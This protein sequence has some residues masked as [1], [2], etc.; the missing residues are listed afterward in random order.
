[1]R[2]TAALTPPDL[3]ALTDTLTDC[4]HD[5]T[6]SLPRLAGSARAAIGS[7]LGLSVPIAAAAQEIA[8]TAMKEP[9][10]ADVILKSLNVPLTPE[11]HRPGPQSRRFT[12]ASLTS[13]LS[14]DTCFRRSGRR[15]TGG[16]SPWPSRSPHGR[17]GNRR[18][19]PITMTTK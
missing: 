9:D 5:V 11:R 2:I 18:K 14:V 13:A 3:I 16:S 4:S 7:H 6:S 10:R 15:R 19:R 12:S 1:M 8:F 17:L